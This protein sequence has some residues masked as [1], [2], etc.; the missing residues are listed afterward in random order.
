[1][2]G[3]FYRILPTLLLALAWAGAPAAAASSVAL[4]CPFCTSQGQTLIGETNQASLVLYG[5]IVNSKPDLTD[6]GNGTADFQIETVLK[7]HDILGD[8]KMITLPRYIPVTEKNPR[9]V[10]FC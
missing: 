2:V 10:I 9:F 3:M 4:C 6:S 1:M 7:K 5:T 8:S